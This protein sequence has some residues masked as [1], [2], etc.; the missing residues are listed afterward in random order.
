LR[1]VAASAVHG[2]R[3]LNAEAFHKLERTISTNPDAG[4]NRGECSF[5][6]SNWCAPARISLYKSAYGTNTTVNVDKLGEVPL[7]QA[8]TK[9]FEIAR[10]NNDTLAF[11]A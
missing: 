2:S 9:H 7:H 10:P 8:L 1:I 5:S 3:G 11:I 6:A 4:A